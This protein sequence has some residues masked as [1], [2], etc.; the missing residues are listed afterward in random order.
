V[1]DAVTR[2][3]TAPVV[4]VVAFAGSSVAARPAAAQS[5]HLPPR[6]QTSEDAFSATLRSESAGFSN[7][8]YEGHYEGLIPALAFRYAWFDAAA[9]LP[10]YR[11]VRNGRSDVG[12]GDLL[13]QTRV[14]VLRDRERLDALGL[15]LAAT[16][17]TG[18]PEHELGMGHV[19][20]MPSVWGTLALGRLGLSARFGY[21]GALA[22]SSE[23][24]HHSGGMSPLV[25]PMNESELDAAAA[26]SLAV[27][28]AVSV[29]LGFYG[30]VPVATADGA[31][32]AAGFAGFGVQNQRFGTS[33]EVHLPLAGD[34][35]TAKLVLE[36]G[37]HF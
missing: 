26:G 27:T 6:V 7:S 3:R 31:S 14:A 36:V 9:S 20:L 35:F 18:N 25:D 29:R 12:P 23:H 24:H 1:R 17:P 16:L 34:P 37:A 4:C 11:I 15:E 30:A 5:C 13:L 2:R 28:P 22:G 10:V 8:E 19:M 21:A 33:V 32:R